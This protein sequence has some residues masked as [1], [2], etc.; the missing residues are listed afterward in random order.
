METLSLTEA[1]SQLPHLLDRVASGESFTITRH[2]SP[3][4]VLSGHDEWMKTRTHDVVVRARALGTELATM[5][6]RLYPGP[7]DFDADATLA[8]LYRDRGYDEATIAN[9]I[10][11][12]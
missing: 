11:R 6:D 8:E 9:L 2:G 1:R 4:A 12:A 10:G 3:I 5:K 7:A